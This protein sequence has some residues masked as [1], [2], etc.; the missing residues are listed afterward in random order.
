M[1][2]ESS[3]SEP[4]RG[5]GA[6]RAL[7]DACLA[8]LLLFGLVIALHADV[9][10]EGKSL[11]HSNRFNPFDYRP[12]PE[13]YGNHVV[14]HT[15][16]AQRNLWTFPNLRDP[17]STW[18]Q[19]EPSTKFLKRAIERREWPFWDPYVCAGAPAM[20]NL[21]A[22]FFF[23]P[24]L[25]MVLLGA[26]PALEN[27]YFL[28]LLWSASFGTFLVLQRHGLSLVACLFGGAAV[29]V[30]GG[31]AQNLGGFMGQTLACLPF[32]LYVT[33]ML[34]DAP[35][36]RRVAL[37][38]V[39][40]AAVALASFPPMLLA[41]FGITACYAAIALA[42]GD[43]GLHTAPGRLR[44]A[45][46]WAIAIVLSG[47]LIAFYY[48]PAVV[49]DR[50]VPQVPQF[51][52]NNG[53]ETMPVRNLYQL[54]SPTL[55]GGVQVYLTGPYASQ[56]FGAHIAYTGIVCIV[57]ALL[58]WP[59]TLRER[60]LVLTCVVVS[61]LMFLKLFGVPP[62]QWIAY[63]PLFNHI[64]FAYY[65]GPPLGFLLVF[66]AAFGV[67]EVVRGRVSAVRVILALV[68]ATG[69][70]GSLWWIA[71]AE[72]AF[73]M[74]NAR[75]WIRDWKFLAVFGSA[76]IACVM[77]GWMFARVAAVRV[78]VGVACIGLVIAEGVYNGAYPKPARWDPFTHPVAYMRVLMKEAS[79][80]RVMT[81]GKPAANGNE[82]F[83]V[84]GIDSLMT[85]NP[86]RMY[87]LYERHMKPSR[88]ILM[89]LASQVPPELVLDRLNAS[90]I[91]T[92]TATPVVINEAQKRGYE[93]RFDNNFTTLF[94]RDT[95][96]RFFYSS[97]YRVMP[98]A[99]ALDAIASAP[100]REILIEED[101]RV[102]TSANVP[103]DPEVQVLHYG[104]NG[105]DLTVD[106]PRPG[107]VYASESY[108]DGWRATINGAP[109]PILA[110]NYAFRAVA[111]PAGRAQISF[112]YW[113]PGLTI[114]L[115]VSAISALLIA[116]LAVV[117]LPRRS[118]AG[119]KAGRSSAGAKAGSA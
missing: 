5:H 24:Y 117:S 94:R 60:S 54:L 70:V 91:G 38:A 20:A 3:R 42:L 45:R 103:G 106:A 81:F 40:Y 26:T 100:R 71:K 85:Y 84:F 30:G 11:I 76:S 77:S 41:I 36:G 39:T 92:Y 50:A 12:L 108:F 113:P 119:A 104:L 109:A 114:G 80:S 99:E 74:E 96:P 55:M 79:F 16:W 56:G 37:V 8:A 15:E 44:A 57:C 115:I 69:A 102:P 34:L 18:W 75:Y 49:L 72:G 97:A 118:S 52:D 86:P 64:H 51:Y 14:P 43:G 89:R 17:G 83:G 90:F 48:L 47:G 25:V 66:L 62:V 93:R 112:R 9:V 10:F 35:T 58:A 101:P 32:P 4:L 13:N 95:L 63:L 116:A 31:M 46:A 82:A 88:E 1:S 21:T 73:A 19:W 28:F 6:S 98:A 2:D 87:Q 22:A 111:V 29:M 27:A 23:P 107:L 67:E 59:R 7:R 61:L 110:A 33:R 65:L 105:F 78:V 53:F 68:V